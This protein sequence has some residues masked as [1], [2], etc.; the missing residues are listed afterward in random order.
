[1]GSFSKGIVLAQTMV[2]RLWLYLDADCFLLSGVLDCVGQVYQVFRVGGSVDR[3]CAGCRG[4]RDEVDDQGCVVILSFLS[5]H[6]SL[7]HP[8]G[9]SSY[10]PHLELHISVLTSVMVRSI[11]V[12]L[13]RRI[14]RVNSVLFS[15]LW[16]TAPILVS[17]ISFCVYVMRG[18]ELTVSVAFTV[19]FS[20][21]HPIALASL[22][23]CIWE[24]LPSLPFRPPSAL[25]AAYL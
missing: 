3:A 22:P 9:Y 18:N 13:S 20:F 7:R 16:T 8:L 14:A 5:L 12:C 19:S 10:T 21:S 11:A 25:M 4:G 6:R 17:I 24:C 2:G 23:F 15:A 1:M